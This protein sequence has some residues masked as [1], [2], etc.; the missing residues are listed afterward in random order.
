MSK[1]Y[2]P[3]KVWVI[4]HHYKVE[5]KTKKGVDTTKYHTDLEHHIRKRQKSKK[6]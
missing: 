4:G 1:C 3:Y 6:T 5:K 2:W